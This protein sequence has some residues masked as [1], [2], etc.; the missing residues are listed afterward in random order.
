M[1][2]LKII[3]LFIVSKAKSGGI[4]HDWTPDGNNEKCRHFGKNRY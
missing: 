3:A 1:K 4:F 2:W